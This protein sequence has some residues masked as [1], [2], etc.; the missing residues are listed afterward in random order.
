MLIRKKA[1]KI[2]KQSITRLIKPIIRP[3]IGV[4]GVLKESVC[5]FKALL[6]QQRERASPEMTPHTTFHY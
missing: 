3:I 6:N 5:S 4:Y 2:S 1:I